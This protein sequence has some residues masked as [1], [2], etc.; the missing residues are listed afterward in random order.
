MLKKLFSFLR[1]HKKISITLILVLIGGTY[2]INGKFSEPID[3]VRYV[4]AKVEKGLLLNTVSG[5]G[6]VSA[7]DQIDI[8]P[9]TSGDI[10][11][12]NAVNGQTV[13]TGTLLIKL[14]TTDATLALNDAET[15]LETAQLELANLLEPLDKLDLLQGENSITSAQRNLD[16][17]KEDYEQ[18]LVDSEQTLVTNY[19]DAYSQVSSTFLQLPDHVND[20]QNVMGSTQITNE[21]IGDYQVLLGDNS[22][23]IESL[24]EHYATAFELYEENFTYFRTVSRNADRKT[25]YGLLAQTL[26]TTRKVSQALESARS[27][28]DDILT[29]DYEDTNIASVV[30]TLRPRVQTDISQINT[31]I[32]RLQ[33]VKDTI[34]DT[35]YETPINIR[36]ALQDI[37]IA[38]ENL[39][40]TELSFEQLKEGPDY[41]DIRSKEIEIRKK[42][43]ALNTAKQA[44]ADHY[45]YAPFAGVVAVVNVKKW[46]TVSSGTK[47]ITLITSQ[48]LA[49]IP[50]NEIDIA[51]VSLG[52]KATIT[53]DAIEGVSITGKVVNIDTLGSVTQGVVNYDVTVNFDIQNENI[54]PG[55]SASVHIITEA[56][57]DVLIVPNSAIQYKNN[58]SIVQV[59]V[60]KGIPKRRDVVI[61]SVN[62]TH[63]EIVS[64]LKEGES[65]VTQTIAVS[66]DQA[67]VPAST[68]KSLMPSVGGSK[69]PRK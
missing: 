13:K 27:M 18:I 57:P 38:E 11:S 56:K 4:T 47:L 14:D 6:Q 55:M 2:Y 59:M 36:N 66:T 67:S 20:L 29:K 50:L 40:E 41:L 44:L 48:Q 42:Q 30:N 33:N 64:G 3:S 26:E 52:Q 34:D 49:I 58:V 46:E 24:V 37:E 51:K 8:T 28:F 62:D 53:L 32:S 16:T 35:V 7:S 43:D 9:K 31:L 21:N 54:K 15:D 22:L 1:S 23:F 17:A 5:F 10:V 65:V 69:Y 12:V 19:E 45:V 63:T 61:G 25:I 68:S 60:D 39:I